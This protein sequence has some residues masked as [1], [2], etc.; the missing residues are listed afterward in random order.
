MG[1]DM[2]VSDS[3]V[4]SVDAHSTRGL[5]V[6]RYGVTLARRGGLTKRDVL[7]TR[8]PEAFAAIVRPV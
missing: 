7:N 6:L 2:Q 4:I 3:V 8:P 5:G 1:R